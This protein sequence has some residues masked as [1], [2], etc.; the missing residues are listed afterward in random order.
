M[1]SEPLLL[2]NFNSFLLIPH[3]TEDIFN[4]SPPRNY[5][6]NNLSLQNKIMDNRRIQKDFPS[7][8]KIQLAKN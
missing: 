1:L 8:L 5:S 6:I 3:T 4:I 2:Q 7:L